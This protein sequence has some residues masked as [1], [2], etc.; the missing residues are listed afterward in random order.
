MVSLVQ[1][2]ACFWV[3]FSA[4]ESAVT[5]V[6]TAADLG[7]NPMIV[8]YDVVVLLRFGLALA[9]FE[10]LVVSWSL[11]Y[12]VEVALDVAFQLLVH[13]LS[14]NQQMHLLCR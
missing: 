3:S 10:L 11:C 1:Q 14:R 2:T 9:T 13:R 6:L 8:D 12:A 4:A 5:P 7:L